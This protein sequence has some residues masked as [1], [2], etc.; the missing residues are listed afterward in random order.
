MDA[1]S[2]PRSSQTSVG[3]VSNSEDDAANSGVDEGHGLEHVRFS[4]D[5]D[6]VTCTQIL[7]FAKFFALHPIFVFRR[8]LPFFPAH[9]LDGEQY[10]R[11]CWIRVG[12]SRDAFVA[13]L[14]NYFSRQGI[15]NH[16]TG[17]SESVDRRRRGQSVK[18]A[19]RYQLLLVS[20]GVVYGGPHVYLHPPDV[21][22]GEHILVMFKFIGP[23]L[24]VDDGPDGGESGVFFRRFGGP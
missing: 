9:A 5:V 15:D 17:R 14:R 23:L 7:S 18:G 11:V 1:Q 24:V 19:V 10:C 6:V 16:H 13:R 2:A 8:G 4:R 3:P 12:T 20:P 22:P 21:L